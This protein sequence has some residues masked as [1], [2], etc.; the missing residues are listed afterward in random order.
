VTFDCQV[1]TGPCRHSNGAP[2]VADGSDIIHTSGVTA[3]AS[4][5]VR[6]YT[7]SIADDPS[8]SALAVLSLQSQYLL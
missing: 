4:N 7:H 1:K 5:T 3:N 6:C 2:E 8:G